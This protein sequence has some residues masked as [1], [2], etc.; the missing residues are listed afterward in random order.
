MQ[1][2]LSTDQPTLTQ[3]IDGVEQGWRA[4][5]ACQAFAHMTGANGAGLVTYA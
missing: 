2:P 5:W 3:S 1:Q 4:L